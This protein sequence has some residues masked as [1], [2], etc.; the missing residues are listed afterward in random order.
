MG[1]FHY[2]RASRESVT[3]PAPAAMLP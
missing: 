3:P 1:H 2:L